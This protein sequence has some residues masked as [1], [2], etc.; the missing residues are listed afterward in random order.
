MLTGPLVSDAEND[1]REPLMLA[2]IVL[3]FLAGCSTEV[4]SAPPTHPASIDAAEAPPA[5][6]SNTL[7]IAPPAAPASAP[8]PAGEG[9]HH[10][11]DAM[12]GMDMPMATHA[13]SQPASQPSTAPASQPAVV[14]TCPM[15]P[16]VLSDK[17]GNC[18][19]CGMKL[20]PKK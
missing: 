8:T 7:A 1:M 2:A 13:N 6:I 12:P 9:M 3:L 14:Y 20:V 16:E 18:P 19:K 5:Q 15:H 10:H 4:P 17:P 11:D